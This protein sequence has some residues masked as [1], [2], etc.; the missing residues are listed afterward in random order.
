MTAPPIGNEATA[1]AMVSVRPTNSAA[2][3]LHSTYVDG[4]HR[5]RADQ[6]GDLH[7]VQ[8]YGLGKSMGQQSG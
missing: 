8:T 4:D 2:T 6:L 1:G 7:C 3:A 5:M